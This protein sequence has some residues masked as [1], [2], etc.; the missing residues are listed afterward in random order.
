M[1]L[2]RASL[3]ALFVASAARAADL[4]TLKGQTYKGDLVSLSNTEVVLDVGGKKE[5]IK[6]EDVLLLNLGGAVEKLAPDV[7]YTLVEL[8]DASQFR[9]KTVAL[10]GADATLTLLSGQV[11]TLPIAKINWLLREA[12]KPEHLAAF[13]ERVLGK[14]K[15]TR[16]IL[17]IKKD[18]VI[19][20]IEGTL[21]DVDAKGENI[22]FTL[23]AGG[24]K[25]A[26]ALSRPLAVYFQRG[27]DPNAK[28]ITCRLTNTHRD[29]I[30]V[31]SVKKDAGSLV[32]VTSC[33]AEMKLPTTN[34]AA[35]DFS[36]GKLSYLSAMSPSSVKETSTEGRVEHFRRDESLEG[37]LIKLDNVK[38]DMG[39]SMHSTTELAYDIGGDYREFK[40]IAGIDDDVGGDD[41]SPTIL[42][43]YGDGNLLKEMA[44]SR[45]DKKRA[46]EINLN[47][48]DVKELKIVVTSGD[49]L[50]LDLGKHLS[51]AEA[52]V[53][54]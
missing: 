24:G 41:Q 15:K 28:P 33:G 9:C 2:L 43:I 49:P 35:L 11:V 20:P 32:L 42:R 21:G 45:K 1:F 34:V 54:K 25:R 37:K 48:K 10:K 3:L 47:V 29:L 16:D 5:S 22:E 36:S 44:F 31:S 53:S 7:A 6:V 12:N 13:K 40:A 27:P 46:Q 14:K 18:D 17:L 8:T 52:R 30:Y 38:Y 4:R 50:G 51:L 26:L 19:N 39:L 23:A